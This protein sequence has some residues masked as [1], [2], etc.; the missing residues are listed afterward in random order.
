[1]VDVREG[2]STIPSRKRCLALLRERKCPDNVIAHAEVV[3]HLAI[4]MA[5]RLGANVNLVSAGALLHDI[6]RSKTHGPGHAPM[7]A[8]IAKK[9]GL[10][11]RIVRII[12]RHLGAGVDEEDRQQLGFPPGIY[13]PETLEEKIV[14]HADSLIDDRR[15][16]ELDAIVKRLESLGYEKAARRVEALHMELN[17]MIEGGL[18]TLCRKIIGEQSS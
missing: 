14:A 13:M 18:D 8:K 10:D 16:G 11:P 2:S 6:G 3:E 12:E 15:C 9:E 7:G 17:K 1:M 4:A 5:E